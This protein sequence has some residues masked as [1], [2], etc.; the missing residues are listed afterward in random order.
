MEL[1]P[2]FDNSDLVRS[3]P[4]ECEVWPLASEHSG[5]G[6]FAALREIENVLSHTYAVGPWQWPD[7]PI[8][9]LSDTHA[10]YMGF[11]RSLAAAGVVRRVGSGP[12][13]F[14]LTSFGVNTR[15]IVGGDCLDK[16]PSNLDMLDS[17]AALMRSGADVTLLAGNHDLRMRL[18]ALSLAQEKTPLT[19]H[20][21]ARMGRKVFPLLH[22]IWIRF[23]GHGGMDLGKLT[24]EECRQRLLPDEDWFVQFPVAAKGLLSDAAIRKEMLKLRKKLSTIETDLAEA[25]LNFRTA[26]AAASHCQHLFFRSNGAYSWFFE[27]MDAVA[28]AGSLLF[29]HAGI[30]DEMCD[31]LSKG[32]LTAVNRRFRDGAHLHPLAFY[33]GSAANLTRT[34]YRTTDKQL[35]AS[36]AQM[37][38]DLGVKMIVQGHVNNSSGQRL[39]VKKGVL[40]LE[41]DITLDRTSRKRQGLQGAGAGATL[42]FPSGD[43]IGLSADYPKAKH[44]N[45]DHALKGTQIL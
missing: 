45:P 40:H 9:F 10:D 38:H 31:L 42:I 22:E 25:E 13:D 15:I 17:L 26:Y 2:I 11:L 37:L 21:F 43:V 7:R 3:V 39:L 18:I 23:V 29:V 33:F 4:R 24:D 27:K 6:S 36:G 12:T 8:V 44:F 35:T 32:G 30:D 16:G 5:P 41:G 1:P 28:R 20:L 19:A 14:R 34:K